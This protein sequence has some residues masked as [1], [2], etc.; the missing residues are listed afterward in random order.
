MY[1]YIG[2]HH[3]SHEIKKNCSKKLYIT[4]EQ[5]KKQIIHLDQNNIR[6]INLSNI[7]EVE[8]KKYTCLTFDDGYESFYKYAFPLLKDKKFQATLF[9]ICNRV[10]EEGFCDKKM[11][12]EI[13]DYG[14]EIGSHTL[15]H[16]D[17]TKV[18]DEIAFK[19]LSESKEILENI[20]GKEVKSFCYPFGKYNNKII[21]LTKCAGYKFALTTNSGFNDSLNEDDL[22]TLKRIAAEFDDD[23]QDFDFKLRESKYPLIKKGK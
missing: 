8:D 10:G 15:S 11:I 16:P 14:I 19:E 2:Y 1:C 9:V 3:I 6:A 23:I 18:S 4:P 22:L 21:E 17:L 13:S 20:I 7:L 12:K 5:F